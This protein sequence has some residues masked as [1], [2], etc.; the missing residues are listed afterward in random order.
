MK[1]KMCLS[2]KVV[3]FYTLLTPI[4][5][6]ASIY[7]LVDGVILHHAATYRVG[8]FSLFGFVVMPLIVLITYFKNICTITT[9]AITINKVNY[10]FANFKFALTE[11]ERDLKDRPLTSL[12]KKNYPFLVITDLRT[13][14]VVQDVELNVF[15]KSLKRMKELLPSKDP[16]SNSAE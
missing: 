5:A 16:S 13:N 2:E 9:D 4:I 14:T 8:V 6:F 1:T 10:P 11:R 7:N 15:N 12:F 3:L